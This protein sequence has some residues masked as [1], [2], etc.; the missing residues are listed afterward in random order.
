MTTPNISWLFETSALKI[1]PSSSPFWYTS[2]LIGPYYVNTQFLCGGADKAAE[3]LALIDAEADQHTTFDAVI[4]SALEAVYSSHQIFH[5]LID[6]MV[7]SVKADFPI[8]EVDYISGGQR[9][10]WFFAPIVA[11]KLGK[12]MLYI[13]ND[14]SMYFADGSPVTDL[15]GKKALNVADL[16]TVGSSYTDKWIPALAALGGK[17]AWSLNGVDRLQHGV[18]NLTAGGIERVHSLFAVQLSLFDEAL[19]R[20]YIDQGQYDMVK[21]YIADPFT[22]MRTFLI[23]HPEFL[24][25]A[26]TSDEKTKARAQKLIGEDLYKLK[27]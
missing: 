14:K 7:T 4:T 2:G 10:D 19:S 9:R 11:K 1:A 8:A 22:S 18:E 13:Y 5:E 3:I 20:S 23:E 24:E 12:P 26:Q 15:T 25:K 21:A 6:Q 17:L 16:L 27:A